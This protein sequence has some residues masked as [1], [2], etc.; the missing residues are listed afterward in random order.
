MTDSY[1]AISAIAQ[2]VSMQQRMM[3][4]VT[5]QTNLGSINLGQES[6]QTWVLTNNY[7]WA[8]SPGWA[9]KWDYALAADP[10][11]E[12][13]KDSSVITDEDILATVQHLGGTPTE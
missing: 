8:S 1:L 6:L 3:A 2:D 5:Q 11:S 4:C 7:L 9:E 10:D 12:P 13:G